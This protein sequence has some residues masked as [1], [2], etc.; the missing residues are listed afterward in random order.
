MPPSLVHP[1]PLASLVF[2]LD[3]T[4][5]D[6]AVGIARCLNHALVRFGH[7]PVDERGISHVIGPPLDHT[8]RSIDPGWSEA[9][10]AELVHVFR[11][12]YAEVGY[13]ENV[14]YPGVPEALDA[15]S[16]AGV[17]LGLCTSKRVDF[18]ESILTLFGLRHHF[19]FLSG[20]DIGVRKADQLASLLQE[21]TI[22]PGSIMIGDRAV[23]I[24]AA[25]ENGLAAVGVLWG[26]GSEEELRRA[27]PMQIL[28][29]PRRLAELRPAGL[30]GRGF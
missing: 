15:L 23:D 3:G 26:H 24:E 12:R 25:R 19:R 20:G 4:I 2:D 6:P 10:I 27:G 18:A 8:F 14:L 5:S 29:N 1:N 9:H 21:G 13:T 22:S 30:R 7:A 17:V 11:E 16:A 28:D